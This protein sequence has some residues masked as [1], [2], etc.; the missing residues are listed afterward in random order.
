MNDTDREAG[1]PLC[2][3]DNAAQ[4]IAWRNNQAISAGRFLCE[5]VQ[6][7]GQLPQRPFVFNLCTDR[8]HF[9]LTFCAAL[10]RGQTNLL[11]PNHAADTLTRLH[12]RYPQS[13]GVSDKALVLEGMDIIPFPDLS[14]LDSDT[15]VIPAIASKHVAA[16][17]FTSGSTGE[18]QP[19]AKT[20]GGLVKQAQLQASR[21]GIEAGRHFLGTVPPQHMY[22]LEST[23]M[24]PLHSGG[25]LHAGQPL[26]AAD[27][28][29]A[30]AELPTPRILITTPLH[31]RIC[32]EENI[33]LPALA[34]TVSAAAALTAELAQR[35]EDAFGA[36]V[37][38]I[39]GC[40]EAGAIATRRTVR[41]ERWQ[42]L[43]G[44]S[45]TSDSDGQAWVEGG[46]VSARTPLQDVIEPA[47]DGAQFRLL[48]RQADLVNIAGK[49]ASLGD[50]NRQLGQI[51]GVRD[52]IFFA[53]DDTPGTAARL[54]ALVV[55]PGLHESE[56]I[57]ALRQ[58][59]DAAFLP[60]PLYKVESL[61][62]T[63]TGKLPRHTLITLLD[64]LQ[65][66]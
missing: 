3:H 37:V 36:P 65:H 30:L 1:L 21:L 29:Q 15:F 41:G 49:R 28:R 39:Y 26:F 14:P 33:T 40:T 34:L 56:I 32:L 18:P 20:W 57:A 10:L 62:R 24:L 8:Y 35:A 25:A 44:V 63:P 38:E 47:A 55:A 51:P 64:G 61:P 23:L 6:L 52:G 22:G 2:R 12:A 66:A 53:P 59:I 19:H 4:P 17:A 48:G 60:R 31:L 45:V 13:Y 27:I 16:I 9:L 46:H 7:A 42:T 54:I 58:K 43:A 5:V 11:P 50:L